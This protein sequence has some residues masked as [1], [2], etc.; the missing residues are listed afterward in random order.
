MDERHVIFALDAEGE[1]VLNRRIR[2]RHFLDGD[3]VRGNGVDA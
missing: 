2:H 3:E 1:G